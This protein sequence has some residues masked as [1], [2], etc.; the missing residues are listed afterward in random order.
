MACSQPF[1]PEWISMDFHR[2]LLTASSTFAT[3]AMKLMLKLMVVDGWKVEENMER[4]G[5]EG[6]E[7]WELEERLRDLG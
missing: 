6:W 5:W 2:L 4:M 1:E 3:V 7:G